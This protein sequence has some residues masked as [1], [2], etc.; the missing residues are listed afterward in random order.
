MTLLSPNIHTSPAKRLRASTDLRCISRS[1]Q[2]DFRSTGI[3]TKKQNN[4]GHE[5]A[6]RITWL[7]LPSSSCVALNR[8]FP[9]GIWTVKQSSI[10]YRDKSLMLGMAKVMVY[11]LLSGMAAIGRTMGFGRRGY[12]ASSGRK[13]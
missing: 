3:R 2:H 11:I 10:Q 8:L 6:T 5:F 13:S 12:G 9:L 7:P 4:V 1:T